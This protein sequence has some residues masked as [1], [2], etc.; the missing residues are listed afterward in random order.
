MPEYG[1]QDIFCAI[2]SAPSGRLPDTKI[3]SLTGWT[4]ISEA[5]KGF[6]D[7]NDSGEVTRLDPSGG[8]F[9]GDVIAGDRAPSISFQMV[10]TDDADGT[11]GPSILEMINERQDRRFQFIVL[12][13]RTPLVSGGAVTLAPSHNN[14]QHQG[15]AVIQSL[16]PWGPGG[17]QSAVFDCSAAISGDYKVFRA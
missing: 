9:I 4:D 3:T 15:S 7:L 16:R 17:R 12:P 5:L 11:D 14:P 8:R 1:T 13:R 6:V 2:R 10:R